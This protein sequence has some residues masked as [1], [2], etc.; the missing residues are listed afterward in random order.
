MTYAKATDKNQNEVVEGLRKAGRT[1]TL[2]HAVGKGVPDLLVGNGGTNYLLEVKTKKGTL[3]PDQEKWMSTWRGSYS[4]V[5][6]VEE[7]LKA[8]E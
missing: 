5:R 8:T 2:L 1:V 4:I 6:T 3:T 7:A